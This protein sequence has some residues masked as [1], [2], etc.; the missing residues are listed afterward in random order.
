M[1]TS[2]LKTPPHLTLTAYVGPTWAPAAAIA[3]AAAKATGAAARAAAAKFYNVFLCP[4]LAAA[5]AFEGP[6]VRL[7]SV[8]WCF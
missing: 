6:C 1:P 7:S 5:D 8:R 3:V 2:L 4:I